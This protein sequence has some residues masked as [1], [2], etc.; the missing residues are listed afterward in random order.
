MKSYRKAAAGAV[1]GVALIVAGLATWRTDPVQRAVVPERYWSGKVVVAEIQL[2]RVREKAT[3]CAASVTRLREAAGG[4]GAGIAGV[5]LKQTHSDSPLPSLER[6]CRN[7]NQ[8]L[9]RAV[10]DVVAAR[11]ALQQVR[12]R[13]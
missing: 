3:E 12:G 6:L 1:L 2:D 7:Y 8:E 11:G 9:E 5:A 13:P 10:D 4:A